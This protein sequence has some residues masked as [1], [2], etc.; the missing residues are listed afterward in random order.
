MIELLK[1]VECLINA[2]IKKDEYVLSDALNYDI[3]LLLHS[4]KQ[5]D[6]THLNRL[7]SS[8]MINS[9]DFY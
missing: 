4:P 8:D 1:I 2:Y 5:L 9:M 7:I 6:T 3:T